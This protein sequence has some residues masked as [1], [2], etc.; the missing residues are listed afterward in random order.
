MQAVCDGPHE[1]EKK[2]KNKKTKKVTPE[3]EK[4]IDTKGDEE[5][6]QRIESFSVRFS[7]ICV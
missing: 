7:L 1:E 4:K 6:K 2:E 3:E 5:G